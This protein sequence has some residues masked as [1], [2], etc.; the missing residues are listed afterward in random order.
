MYH[1]HSVKKTT[2]GKGGK[3]STKV[4]YGVR[5]SLD[6]D[7]FIK[8][9]GKERFEKLCETDSHYK[10][11]ALPKFPDGTSWIWGQFLYIWK[12]CEHDFNGNT[13]FT[14]NAINEYEKCMKTSLS[15]YEKKMLLKIKE[16]ACESI[17]ELEN[18][19]EK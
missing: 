17:Y 3:K 11:Y 16:W 4:D 8:R 15:V 9:F 5:N 12:N 6:R 10:K 14:F 19:G 2:I 1:P 7:N 13:I 18:G